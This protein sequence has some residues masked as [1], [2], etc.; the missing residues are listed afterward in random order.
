MTTP[1]RRASLAI[2]KRTPV[3]P[4]RSRL[5]GPV[6]S[7]AFDDAPR[8]ATRAGAEAL[9]RAGV[10]GT[11]YLC[12][13]HAGGRFEGQVQHD[14]A[15]ARRLALAGHEIG[16]HGF[17]HLDA[18]LAPS[19]R[20]EEDH[21]RNL[22]WI[23][24]EVGA[25]APRSFAYPFGATS[26]RAKRFY[27][28]RFATCRGVLGGLN[29]AWIDLAELR[30]FLVSSRR[31]DARRIARLARLAR[32]RTAWLILFTH[33]VC[34]APSPYGCRPHELSA[35]VRILRDEGLDVLPVATAADRVLGAR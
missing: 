17:S 22:A 18:T 25:G 21:A 19:A 20:L 27:S 33:D 10:R 1:W 35:L 24:D 28:A 16:C 34:D 3:R 32:R 5:A 15:D 31:F 14:L 8:S 9:E 11:Y 4:V 30:A 12:G 7:I 23:A 26:W 2:A 6:A 29:A 13:A